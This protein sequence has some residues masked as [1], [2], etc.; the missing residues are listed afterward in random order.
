MSPDVSRIEAERI[1]WFDR[2]KDA[3]EP[4][5]VRREFH[6]EAERAEFTEGQYDTVSS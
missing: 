1:P 6:S 4:D 5:Y 3:P 2:I